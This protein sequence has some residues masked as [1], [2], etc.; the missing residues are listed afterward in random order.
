[1]KGINDYDSLVEK[2]KLIYDKHRT[3]ITLPLHPTY[4]PEIFV[5]KH[6]KRRNNPKG[7]QPT[8]H[9]NNII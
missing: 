5:Q 2:L 6:Q 8:R 7:K 9:E 1:M 4:T 3:T